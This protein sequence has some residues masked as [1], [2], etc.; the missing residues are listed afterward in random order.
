MTRLLRLPDYRRFWAASTVSVFG[1]HVT[2]LALQILVVVTLRASGLELGL[3]NA[4]RWLPYLLFGL[5]A[6]VLVDRYRRRPVL[7][8]TDVGR[9]VLLCGIPALYFLELLTLPVLAAF[10]AVFGLL[11]LLFDA[12]DQA[13]LPQLVPADRLTSAYARLEQSDSVA[14]TAGPLLA[15]VLVKAVG[16]PLAILVDAVSY[17]WSAILLATIR[18]PEPPPPPAAERHLW[19]E[20]REGLSWV[21]GHRMLAPM[22]LTTHGWFLC[23]SLLTVAFVVYVTRDLNLGALGLGI[24]YACGGAGA[25]LGGALA[26]WA[27]R[28]FDAGRTKVGAEAVTPLTWLLVP[29][30]GPGPY[31][32]VLVCVAQF[33]FWIAM[34]IKG[35]N[36]MSYRQCVTPDGLRGRMNATMRSLNRAAIVVGAPLGGL[37]ADT[38]GVRTALWVGIAGFAVV[39]VALAVSPFRHASY[40][41]ALEPAER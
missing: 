23:H 41:E 31:A 32:L 19:R 5:V 8:G 3:V 36:E 25:V 21:Y 13:Y 18:R 14:Q 35:P 30:A 20:L 29:F 22:A 28:R 16:A 9:A 26:G 10:V 15:G 27:G 40:A 2:T 6:G 4:A 37:L 24:A 1:T 11:S 7:I 34:G 12:A 38:A 33:L 17:L 39:A